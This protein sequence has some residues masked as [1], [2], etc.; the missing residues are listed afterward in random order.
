MSETTTKAPAETTAGPATEPQPTGNLPAIAHQRQAAVYAPPG[1]KGILVAASRN[2]AEAISNIMMEI[3]ENPVEKKG[4]NTFHNYKYARIQ[5]I[6]QAL[7]P[8]MGKHGILVMQTEVSRMMFDNDAAISITYEFTIAHKT[9]EVW[10]EKIMQTG[11]CNCRANNGKFDDKA[12]NKCHTAARKYFMLSLFQIPTE[13]ENDPDRGDNDDGGR[14]Q[15]R[16][17]QSRV[18]SPQPS[19]QQQ[20]T[21]TT[22]GQTRATKPDANGVIN[23]L[24]HGI[25][26][27]TNA[28]IEAV[29]S[30]KEPAELN[31]LDTANDSTLGEV[32]AK[33]HEQYKL[34]EAAVEE[35]KKEF[36]IGTPRSS[37]SPSPSAGADEAAGAKSSQA[38]K[39]AS[40]KAPAADKPAEKTADGIPTAKNDPEGFLA[41]ASEKLKAV[42]EVDKLG[43]VI[44]EIEKQAVGIFPP[45]REELSAMVK[46][47]EKR[48]E[49]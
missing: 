31:R 38:E 24:G 30:V 29:K 41:W 12:I 15:Q 49:P 18:P 28:F 5:D 26:S 46:A 4:L 25:K 3:S 34:I 32:H 1:D 35:K 6:L 43:D 21:A 42:T 37:P 17:Q 36:G 13:E 27:W 23:M 22:T 44:G 10:P 33:A 20:G 48:L 2:V 47:A 45:D 7:V 39:P 14:G 8:L 40:D 19:G 9:G 11:L 16:E